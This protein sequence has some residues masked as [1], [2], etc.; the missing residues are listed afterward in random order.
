MNSAGSQTVDVEE[1]G[2]L[3]AERE[4]RR[5]AAVTAS[6]DPDVLRAALVRESCERRRAEC[7]ADMQTSVAK[8][9]LD[10]LVREP[11][12]DGFFGALTSTMVEEGESHACALWLLDEAGQRCE[13]WMVVR[14]KIICSI[15][16]A[17]RPI[18]AR[19]ARR[20][21][22]PC[23]VMAGH[24]FA[25]T[26]GWTQTDRVSRRRS[27]AA[28]RRSATSAGRCD[29]TSRCPRRSC[30]ARARSAG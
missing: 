13:P 5:L 6:N 8:L 9:A 12:V 14:R 26:P 7:R 23:D 20:A 30:S 17:R 24:L 25:Y 10:L 1:G 22:F 3:E 15:C 4:R 29:G 18:D 2:C 16:A 21:R 27:A 28:R 19:S 11:D